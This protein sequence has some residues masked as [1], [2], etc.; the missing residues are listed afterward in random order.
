MEPTTQ[1]L[2]TTRQV[3]DIWQVTPRTVRNWIERGRLRATRIRDDGKMSWRIDAASLKN[4]RYDQRRADDLNQLIF[5]L[6]IPNHRRQLFDSRDR[7]DVLDMLIDILKLLERGKSAEQAFEIALFG[8]TDKV[9]ALRGRT[10]QATVVP[11]PFFRG[12]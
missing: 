4:S 7:E 9:N 11:N 6:E 1:R 2:L 12:L 3:A 8:E 10:T 5:L